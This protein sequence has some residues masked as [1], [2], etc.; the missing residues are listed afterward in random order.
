MQL[1][2]EDMAEN[3]AE[4]LLSGDRISTQALLFELFVEFLFSWGD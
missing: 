2:G 4:D 1:L 3:D